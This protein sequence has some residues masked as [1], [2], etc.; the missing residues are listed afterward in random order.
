M[1]SAAIEHHISLYNLREIIGPEAEGVM[2]YGIKGCFYEKVYEAAEKHIQGTSTTLSGTTPTLKPLKKVY[3]H[4]V[5]DALYYEYDLDNATY[6]PK[7]KYNGPC[8]KMEVARRCKAGIANIAVYNT[9]QEV[10]G[11][12]TVPTIFCVKGKKFDSSKASDWEITEESVHSKDPDFNDKITMKEVRRA[13]KLCFDEEIDPRVRTTAQKNFLFVEVTQYQ[14]IDKG[15]KTEHYTYTLTKISPPWGATQESIA[16][17]KQGLKQRAAEKQTNPLGRAMRRIADLGSAQLIILQYERINLTQLIARTKIEELTQ[18]E[19]DNFT[20]AFDWNAV[21]KSDRT[22]TCFGG[23][24]PMTLQQAC[25]E[26]L[27]SYIETPSFRK[28]VNARVT[29]AMDELFGGLIDSC[30]LHIS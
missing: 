24:V 18:N 14:D 6:L 21:L 20:D 10:Q 2:V 17:F 22:F 15:K 19:R 16:T 12:G 30:M 27:E 7:I 23:S 5:G 26:R 11:K 4:C 29:R 1:S 8:L 25:A 28:Q 9:I 3:D 13:G